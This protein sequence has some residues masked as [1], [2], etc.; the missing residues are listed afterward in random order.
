MSIEIAGGISLV[1]LGSSLILI[2]FPGI[3]KTLGD[4][5]NRPISTDWP[6]LTK[7]IVLVFG[8]LFL[9]VGTVVTLSEVSLAVGSG[10]TPTPT[11]MPIALPSDTPS[12]IVTLFSTDTLTPST[13][14]VPTDR[15]TA[16]STATPTATASPTETPT[17]T[18]IP[19]ATIDPYQPQGECIPLQP[20]CTYR[21]R[22]GDSYRLIALNIYGQARLASVIAD[23]NRMSDGNYLKLFTG[24]RLFVP[25]L[26]AIPPLPYPDCGSGILPCQY[27]AYQGDT[28]EWISKAFYRTY[29][30]ADIIRQV[31][32]DFSKSTGESLQITEGEIIVVPRLP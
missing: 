9:T 13:T 1:V 24:T 28:Y 14:P 10:Q 22:A 18:P 15:P 20:P 11:N 5:L 30:N 23:A 3:A 12:A 2:L 31:N 29:D 17:E 4:F 27:R 26:N 32:T 7:S 8:V 21:V 19:S 16:T 6:R 25:S